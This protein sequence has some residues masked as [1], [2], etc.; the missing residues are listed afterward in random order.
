MVFLPF[1]M[2]VFFSRNFAE[3]MAN[4]SDDCAG[5]LGAVEIIKIPQDTADPWVVTEVEALPLAELVR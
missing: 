3:L 4:Q 2:P 5:V 1:G